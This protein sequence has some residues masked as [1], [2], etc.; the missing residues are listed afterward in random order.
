M[1]VANR[2][3]FIRENR[4]EGATITADEDAVTGY[5]VT[6]VS[7]SLH[8]E[9]WRS[10][11]I[12]ST[13]QLD[14]GSPKTL[15]AIVIRF[16]SSRDPAEA[17]DV[18][19]TSGDSITVNLSTVSL[20]ATDVDTFTINPDVDNTLGYCTILLD[21]EVSARYCTIEFD[22][23]SRS[24]AGF[25]E[26]E[27]VQIGPLWFPAQNYDTN[28]EDSEA[29][30]SFTE[31]SDLSAATFTQSRARRESFDRSWEALTEA[32]YES[33]REFQRTHGTTKRF[34]YI[35]RTSANLKTNVIIARFNAPL[36]M[37]RG[38]EAKRYFIR[39]NIIENR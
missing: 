22:L 16:R 6:N 11:V 15:Q 14:F 27:E 35:N 33:W 18:A 31:I 30:E 9:R 28:A 19:V 32:E 24:G 8:Y 39:A 23:T 13:L 10:T 29:S 21:D 38:L 2:A 1:A 20:G 36:I 4:V 25:F 34:V 5:P 3:C 37:R 17:A 7:Q 26:V 12:P